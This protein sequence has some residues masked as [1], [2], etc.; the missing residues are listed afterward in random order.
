MTM[1]YNKQRFKEKRRRLR[2]DEERKQTIEDIGFKVLRFT[3]EE[4]EKQIEQVV[5]KIKQTITNNE[6]NS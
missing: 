2:Y 4:V 3:N 1:I 6:R 5:E